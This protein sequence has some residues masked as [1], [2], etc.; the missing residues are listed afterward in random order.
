M[1]VASSIVPFASWTVSFQMAMALFRLLNAAMSVRFVSYPSKIEKMSRRPGS[2]LSGF[3]SLPRLSRKALSSFCVSLSSP[4]SRHASASAST[5]ADATADRMYACHAR[6][7][8]FQLR[9]TAIFAPYFF[10]SSQIFSEAV[11]MRL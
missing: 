4:G 9:F 3:R 7:A 5:I 11:M 6:P 10:V 1:S 2:L 8:V